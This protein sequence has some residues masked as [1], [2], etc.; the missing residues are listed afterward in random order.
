MSHPHLDD[1]GSETAPRK[2]Q[3]PHRVG[4]QP[5]TPYRPSLRDMEIFVTVVQC[6]SFS[7]AGRQIGLSP[8]SVSRSVNALEDKLGAQL[9]NRTSRSLS[10]SDVGLLFYQRAEEVLEDVRVMSLEV[11]REHQSLSGVLRVHSRMLVGELYIAPALREFMERYPKIQ[12][13]LTL[14]NEIIDLVEQ[15][16]DIDIRIGKLAD[17]SLIARKLVDARRILCAAPQYLEGRPP[18]ETPAD[19]SEHNCLA[20]RTNMGDVAWRFLGADGDLEEI[21]ISGSLLTNSGPVLKIALLSGMGVALMP[22]WSV[23]ED[24][25]SGRLVRLLPDYRISFTSFENGVYAVYSPT[26]HLPMKA[27]V[28]IDYLAETFA[29]AGY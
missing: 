26:R 28:F 15:N 6:G 2:S 12:V 16:V 27:R 21:A 19:L 11:S 10:L 25:E 1:E 20:Y 18:I 7:A 13:H 14:S 3:K 23:R 5:V 4:G 22:E 29:R 8:A 9:L 24:L 17:S